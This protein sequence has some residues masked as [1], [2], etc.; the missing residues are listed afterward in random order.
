MAQA[1]PEQFE[2][3]IVSAVQNEI[4]VELPSLSP[5]KPPQQSI[6]EFLA[7]YG[8]YG[9]IHSRK[10][11]NLELREQYYTQAKK[12]LTFFFLVKGEYKRDYGTGGP[13]TQDRTFN[14]KFLSKYATYITR[15]ND[16]L[17]SLEKFLNELFACIL[18]IFSHYYKRLKVK[19]NKHNC[20]EALV[21]LNLCLWK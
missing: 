19:R 6:E 14:S 13:T 7:E 4:V 17:V 18:Y 3:F 11:C 20:T 1:A 21:Y 10:V 8:V 15:F 9:H 16:I 12:V 2:N 5:S